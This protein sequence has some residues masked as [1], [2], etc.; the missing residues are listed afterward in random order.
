M[1]VPFGK[2]IVGGYDRQVAQRCLDLGKRSIHSTFH[3]ERPK[4][5]F[6]ERRRVGR[7]STMEMTAR[8]AARW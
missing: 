3:T 5:P 7:H 6:L 2:K 1:G 4:E 8:S